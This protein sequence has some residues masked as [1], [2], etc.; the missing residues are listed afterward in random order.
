[1]E[2]IGGL[3]ESYDFD[4]QLNRDVNWTHGRPRCRHA[5][6]LRPVHGYDGPF[7]RQVQ[8]VTTIPHVVVMWNEGGFATTGVCAECVAEALEGL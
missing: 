4:L 2:H 3:W 6:G 7:S 8:W 5:S 1:M